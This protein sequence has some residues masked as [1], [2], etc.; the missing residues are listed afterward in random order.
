MKIS[1]IT[2]GSTGDVRP[3]ILLGRELKKRGHIISICAFRNFEATART[4]GF[5]FI[6]IDRDA[7]AFMKN[8]LSNNKGGIDYVNNIHRELKELAPVMF[9]AID[10][11]VSCSDIVI[12]TYFGSFVR[13]VAEKYNKLFVQTHFFPMDVN[14]VSPIASA[15]G[16]CLGHNYYHFTYKLGYLL[17]NLLERY[18]TKKYKDDYELEPNEITSS[19]VYTINGQKFPVIYAMSR[20][21]LPPYSEWEDNIHVVGYFFEEKTQNY[22]PPQELIDFLNAG[23]KPIYIGFGSVMSPKIEKYLNITLKALERTNIR[24]ILVQG[25]KDFTPPENKNVFTIGA[26]PHDYIFDKVKAVIHHGGAGTF[27]AG[28][29]HAK[30]TYIVPFGGDQSFNALRAYEL[31]I[32][33]KPLKQEFFTVEKMERC[34]NELVENDEYRINAEILSKKLADEQG[35]DKAIE[36]IEEYINA[37][38]AE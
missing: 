21:V 20:Y 17:I 35:I 8:V 14:D 34:L 18:L 6:P 33:P 11:A 24:A 36:I 2:I 27:A 10:K 9:D 37:N 4:E 32:G 31:G 29:K 22:T 16:F 25:W 7:S 30:P 12:S 13:R 3:Y 5:D 38:K 26:L 15:K 19:P 1:M 23:E 28:I